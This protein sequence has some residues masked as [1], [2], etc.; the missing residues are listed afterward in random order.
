M[1][2]TKTS[3]ALG[4]PI[5]APDLPWSTP[6]RRT[7]LTNKPVLNCTPYDKTG[8]PLTYVP[9]VPMSPYLPTIVPSLEV[10]NPRSITPIHPLAPPSLARHL[11]DHLHMA[12]HHGWNAT[13]LTRL[14]EGRRE[15]KGNSTGTKIVRWSMRCMSGCW[16][17][18]AANYRLRG[19]CPGEKP[20]E[21]GHGR[22]RHGRDRHGINEQAVLTYVL[23]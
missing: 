18:R 11:H 16:C 3:F 8:P 12:Y 9:L 22:D 2:Q 14:L 7:K 13:P 21:K 19:P 1:L 23:A 6:V 4:R 17:R 20:L 5:R 10:P 15:K